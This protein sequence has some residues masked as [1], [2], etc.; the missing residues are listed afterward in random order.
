MLQYPT[1]KLTEVEFVKT[2]KIRHGRKKTIITRNLNHAQ[3]ETI[4]THKKLVDNVT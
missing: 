4:L 2:K 1:G 3:F